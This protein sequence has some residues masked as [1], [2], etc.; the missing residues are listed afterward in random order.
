[1]VDNFKKLRKFILP[2]FS[3]SKNYLKFK[4]PKKQLQTL[5]KSWA[6]KLVFQA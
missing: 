2:N 6:L 4:K 3:N 1:M 5:K